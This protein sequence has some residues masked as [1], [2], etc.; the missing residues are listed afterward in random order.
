LESFSSVIA[1]SEY[2][3]GFYR[4]RLFN[5]P[6]GRGLLKVICCFIQLKKYNKI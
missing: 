5:T 3:V 6:L 4:V 1:V 2:H